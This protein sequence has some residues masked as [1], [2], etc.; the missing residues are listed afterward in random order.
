MS[1][2]SAWE[3]PSPALRLKRKAAAGK[4]LAEHLAATNAKVAKVTKPEIAE[5]EKHQA[6][7][8]SESS[9]A[10][11]KQ[12]TQ[13]KAKAKQQTRPKAKAERKVKKVVKPK[14]TAAEKK[15]IHRAACD[16]WRSRWLKKGVPRPAAP[17]DQPAKAEKAKKERKAPEAQPA[18]SSAAPKP[19]TKTQKATS[20][21]K[22]YN[23]TMNQDP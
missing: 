7:S 5:T 14:R 6:I 4:A 13:P 9:K 12:Q 11:A 2:G 8:D 18:A 1:P 20:K 19:K 21:P 23:T 16:R 10:K 3:Q 15:Q 17:E 22:E